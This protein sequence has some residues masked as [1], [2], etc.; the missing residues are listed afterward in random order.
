M[1]SSDS[2]YLSKL[3]ALQRA[4]STIGIGL[5]SGTSADGVDAAVVEFSKSEI[6]LLHLESAKY[7]KELREKVLKSKNSSIKEISAL[8]VEIG[9]FFAEAAFTASKVVNKKIDFIGSH[10]QTIFHHN[11]NEQ[12]KSTFQIGCADTIAERLNTFIVSDFR[13]RDIAAGG[14]GAPLTP[15]ADK[16]F[17]GDSLKV[18]VNIGGISNL[19]ILGKKQILGFDCGPGNAPLDRLAHLLTEGK[20]EFDRDG[21]LAASG[22]IEEGILKDLK[23]S[24]LFVKKSP[25]K[26]TGTEVYGDVFVKRLIELNG[27]VSASLL[28]TVTEFVAWC[29]GEACSQQKISS[30]VSIL[31]AGGGS[32]NS[33][34][35]SRISEY[36]SPR[37]LYLTD[38]FGIPWQARESMAFA[39]F[40]HDLLLGMNTSLPS[41]TGAKHAAPLGKVSF[42][43]AI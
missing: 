13:T 21:A 40:A 20:Q 12:T 31:L 38:D 16:R 35:R 36:V 37:P 9:N 14:E 15:Y 42:P 17:F 5:M 6:K 32:Q 4:T 19:T 18:I 29:I 28:T 11:G 34:L 39:L 7:P 27:G 26:S 3:T 41:V 30:D 43:R 25:P 8:N 10:G 22:L 2:N 24:D 33:Y 1:K 23:E